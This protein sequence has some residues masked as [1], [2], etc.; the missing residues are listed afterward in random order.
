MNVP[1]QNSKEL[2]P[3]TLLEIL[4][5]YEA[6]PKN[7]KSL[8]DFHVRFERIHPFQDGN[9]TQIHLQKAA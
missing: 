9:V 1:G 6:A 3:E 4:Q 5:A 7:L 2:R 8:L